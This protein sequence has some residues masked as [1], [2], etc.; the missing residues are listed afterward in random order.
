[1]ADPLK[2]RILPGLPPFTNSGVDY[3]GPV[4][5][6]KEDQPVSNRVIFTCMVSRA[7][8]L[9]VVVILETD[10]CINALQPF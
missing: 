5:I 9:E 6:R 3:F 7:V 1:M 10:A 2:V 4:K 8:H